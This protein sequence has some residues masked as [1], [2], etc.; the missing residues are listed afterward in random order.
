MICSGLKLF[1]GMGAS[2]VPGQL[3]QAA[4]FNSAQSGQSEGS[5]RL[6]CSKVEVL[7]N[8]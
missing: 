3:S 8:T 7:I 6:W 4:W 1:F 2:L 5:Q